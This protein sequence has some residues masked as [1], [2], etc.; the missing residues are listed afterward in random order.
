MSAAHIPDT[1]VGLR[2]GL[3]LRAT[4]QRDTSKR[5]NKVTG[6]VSHVAVIISNNEAYTDRIVQ[7]WVAH[8]V[9]G[10]DKF[11]KDGK[12]LGHSRSIRIPP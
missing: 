12:A 9:T 8:H 1:S 3:L 5:E 6:C 2:T 4:S 7:T 10:C 11:N